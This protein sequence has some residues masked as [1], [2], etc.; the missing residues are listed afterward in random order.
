MIRDSTH[1]DYGDP[2]HFRRAKVAQKYGL[3]ALR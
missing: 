3:F 1:F 2:A